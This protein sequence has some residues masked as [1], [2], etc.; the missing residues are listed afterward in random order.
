MRAQEI[1]HAGYK[2]YILSRNP[3]RLDEDGD[4]LDDDEIDEEADIAARAENVYGEIRLEGKCTESSYKCIAI[5]PIPTQF[6]SKPGL[7]QDR[8]NL[9]TL[10]HPFATL[11]EAS[12]KPITIYLGF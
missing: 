10:R 5:L 11:S 2:R 7:R 3:P 12:D 9:L 4:E 8:A 6:Y 1:E